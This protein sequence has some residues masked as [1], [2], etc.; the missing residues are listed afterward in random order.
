MTWATLFDKQQGI[1]DM[2]FATDRTAQT[3]PF[4][5]PLVD[6]TLEQKITQTTNAST[7]QDRSA[8]QED[9]NLYS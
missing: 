7:M 2:H 8:I 6:H 3:T 4:D 1:F 9:P 5:G